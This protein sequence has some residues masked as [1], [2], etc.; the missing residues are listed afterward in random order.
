MPSSLVEK[1]REI[2][3]GSVRVATVV[4]FPLGSCCTE[5]KVAETRYALESGVEEVDMVMNINLFKSRD[6]GRVLEDM[7][8]G[9]QDPFPS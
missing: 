4:G 8:I 5:A 1:V 3:G 9:K 7:G 6:Y 2:A